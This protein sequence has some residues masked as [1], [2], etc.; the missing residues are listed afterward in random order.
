[1]RGPSVE[2]PR[3]C[4]RSNVELDEV[5]GHFEIQL[6]PNAA[7]LRYASDLHPLFGEYALEMTFS[8]SR[9]DLERFLDGSGFPSLRRQRDFLGF[10]ACPQA[11]YVSMPMG[12]QREMP[13]GSTVEVV[14]LDHTQ[15]RVEVA[16]VGY[17]L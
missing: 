1:M 6:P 7:N 15:A 11:E 14:V 2:D 16:V 10:D 5:T 8:M 13:T 9:G 12:G 17:D 3:A 4:A